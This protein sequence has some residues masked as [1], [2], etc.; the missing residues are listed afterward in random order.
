MHVPLV[1]LKIIKPKGRANL[2]T[3][4]N[5]KDKGVN[6][7]NSSNVSNTKKSFGTKLFDFLPSNCLK[8]VKPQIN[9]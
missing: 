7:C 9:I 8:A 5:T 2:R 1:S 4:K 6:S 3:E